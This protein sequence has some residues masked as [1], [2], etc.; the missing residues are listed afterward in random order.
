[1]GYAKYLEDNIEIFNERM[2]AQNYFSEQEVGSFI[3]DSNKSIKVKKFD[4]K[5]KSNE[6]RYFERI[7]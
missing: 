4:I 3:S 2:D 7:F 6:K 1:M 5:T